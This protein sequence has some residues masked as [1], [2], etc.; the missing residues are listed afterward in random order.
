MNMQKKRNYSK[1][2]VIFIF[3]L[4]LIFVGLE[5]FVLD[6][7]M[8]MKYNFEDYNLRISSLGPWYRFMPVE[9]VNDDT[10]QNLK[11]TLAYFSVRIPPN[12]N[13]AS[14]I[15][16]YQGTSNIRLG[17]EKAKDKYDF[18]ET[19]IDN[20]GDWKIAKA[21]FRLREVFLSNY[22]IKNNKLTFAISAPDVN[23]Q[24]MIK[25]TEINVVLTK[26]KL[27]KKDWQNAYARIKNKLKK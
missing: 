26:E 24:N 18:V 10:F 19:K 5:F 4:L 17:A 27:A 11:D 12:F 20:S 1:I 9:T 22:Y 23:D 2:I 7:K 13:L 21:N 25:I 14:V 6:K 8:E 3:C 16:K 15:V